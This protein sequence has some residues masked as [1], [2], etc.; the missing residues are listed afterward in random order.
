MGILLL[1]SV[2]HYMAD[3][4]TD[5]MACDKIALSTC[6]AGASFNFQKQCDCYVENDCVSDEDFPSETA[7]YNSLVKVGTCS[8]A[9]SSTVSLAAMALGLVAIVASTF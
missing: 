3:N 6:I 9:T 2:S 4:L 5:N 1:L 8:S 7:A